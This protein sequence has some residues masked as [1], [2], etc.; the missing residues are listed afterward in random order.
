MNKYLLLLSVFLLNLPIWAADPDSSETSETLQ[1]NLSGKSWW[2]I[3]SGMTQ[4]DIYI[5]GVKSGLKTP[6]KN[7]SLDPGRHSIYL[8]NP[9]YYSDTIYIEAIADSIQYIDLPFRDKMVFL[10]VSSKQNGTLIYRG[11]HIKFPVQKEPISIIGGPIRFIKEGYETQEYILKE[12]P[13]NGKVD[14]SIELSPKSRW[15]AGA[16]SFLWPGMGQQYEERDFSAKLWTLLAIG[17]LSYGGVEMIRNDYDFS[18]KPLQ[19][20]LFAIGGVWS[21]SILD[22]ILFFPYS[23]E[24]NKAYSIQSAP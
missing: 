8:E 12:L 9:F 20:A 16:L 10:N 22:A 7:L 1:R 23:T 6:Y 4:A 13:L 17:A 24:K 21:I 2:H 14:F 5:N 19:R 11:Q 15:K 3:S 18:E